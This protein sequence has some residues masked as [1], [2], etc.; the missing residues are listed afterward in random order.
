MERAVPDPERPRRINIVNYDA[1]WP[2]VFR[3]LARELRRLF[4][5]RALRIDHIGSTSV[6]ELAAK[7]II[8]IQ[9][10]V[11][12]SSNDEPW[13]SSLMAAGWE[14][15]ADND[16]R[17][18]RFFAAPKPGPAGHLHVREAGSLTEQLAL[19]FRDYL[20]SNRGAAARYEAFKRKLATRMWR[21][22][23]EYAEAKTEIVWPLLHEAYR[24][25]M[26]SG[27]RPGPSDA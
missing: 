22:G 19:V 5:N 8:D 21:D 7:P 9:V 13:R 12:E 15:D 27:W 14:W 26:L 23:D 11:A 18:K 25:S 6:P 1:S 2:G 20:R 17:T 4:G 24:W 16:E 3:D 10:S